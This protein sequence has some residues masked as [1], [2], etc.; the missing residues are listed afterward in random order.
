MSE[1][2][3][4]VKS[5]SKSR[6]Y[7][8][9]FF[10]YGFKTRDDFSDKSGRTYD[11]ERRRIESWLSEYIHSDYT[12]N[13]KNISIS[14][15]SNLLFTNPL[16][17]VWKS[18]SFTD[19]DIM[20]HFFLM[21]ILQD[22]EERTIEELTNEIFL[23]YDV[24]FESQLVRKKVKEYEKEGLLSCK[25]YG[26]QFRYMAIPSL[27]YIISEE[28]PALL[29]ALRFH[30]IA[31]P[32]GIVGSTIL[33]NQKTSNDIFTTKHG[34]FAHTLEDEML[35]LLFT[36]MKEQRMISLVIRSTKNKQIQTI[37][38]TPLKVFVS[39][40]TGRRYIC[41][42]NVKGQ[43]FS[44][45]RLDQIKEVTLLEIDPSYEEH[46]IDLQNNLPKVFGVSFGT[47]R[48]ND[49]IKLTI[50]LDEK[51]EPYILDRLKKE[52]H[53]GTITN[54]HEN[55]YVYEIDVFDGNEM[56]P[57]IRTFIG[58]IISFESNNEFLVRKFYRDL[59]EMKK[60]Y[61]TREHI[62]RNNP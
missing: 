35:L 60:L 24:L 27:K 51:K 29:D 26:K 52:G 53:G 54:I 33:D 34:F 39:T 7:V 16:Y 12:K 45:I 32:L 5:F 21:D 28:L 40:R 25:K 36:A 59:E 46:K 17:R 44:N 57:W 8:R 22:G 1:F 9:D 48:K 62:V 4:L 23:N 6:E 38:A 42:H 55:T 47:E 20:L 31:S 58:R 43:R 19:N 56:L 37:Q 13:G 49:H 10:V 2:Q 41:V 50:F 11:N 15:D 14:I 61:D 3:E 18:K 30:H